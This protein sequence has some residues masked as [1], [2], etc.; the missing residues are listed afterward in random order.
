MIAQNNLY[1]NASVVAVVAPMTPILFYA[2]MHWKR[3]KV[4][5]TQDGSPQLQDLGQY[6]LPHFHSIG[7]SLCVAILKV[8]IRHEYLHKST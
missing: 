5:L 8:P 2:S 4:D 3:L 6:H 1:D 7:Y